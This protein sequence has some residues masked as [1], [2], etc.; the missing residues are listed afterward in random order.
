[1]IL[2]IGIDIIEKERIKKVFQKYPENFKRL[3]LNPKEWPLFEYY[4]RNKERQIEFLAGRFAAKEAYMKAT[5]LGLNAGFASIAVLREPSG[6]PYIEA[7]SHPSTAR[8]LVTITHHRTD[9]FAQVII[10]SI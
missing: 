10:E 1:V 5:G 2:G 4:E 6:K 3:I 8:V 7:N 9:A